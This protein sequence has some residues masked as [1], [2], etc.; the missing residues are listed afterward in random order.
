[1]TDRQTDR[2]RWTDRKAGWQRERERGG[3][4]GERERERERM[5]RG[6]R[7]S[8]RTRKEGRLTGRRTETDGPMDGQKSWLAEREGVGEG[9]RMTREIGNQRG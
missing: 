4:G 2:N 9:E 3:G 7:Q 8:E 6:D 5:A 1:M